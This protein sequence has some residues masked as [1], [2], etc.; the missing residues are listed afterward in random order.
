MSSFKPACGMRQMHTQLPGVR[1]Y[2]EENPVYIGRQEQNGRAIVMAW[3]EGTQACVEIDLLDLIAGLRRL[4][5]ELFA[6]SKLIQEVE[7]AMRLARPLE[8]PD[9]SVSWIGI[10]FNQGFGWAWSIGI[11]GSE[12]YSAGGF[13]ATPL[14]ALEDL[15]LTLETLDK[16]REQAEWGFNRPHP[17]LQD[18]MEAFLQEIEQGEGDGPQDGTF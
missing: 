9:P 5:P 10:N 17:A 2:S 8:A 14:K 15:V 1:E 4:R 6:R 11:Q 12:K 3:N 16:I 7:P 18:E 13:A